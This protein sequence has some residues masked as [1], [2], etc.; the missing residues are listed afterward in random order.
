MSLQPECQLTCDIIC[1]KGIQLLHQW[2]DL[3]SQPLF[4]V[5]VRRVADVRLLHTQPE[6]KQQN[7]N[8]SELFAFF[9]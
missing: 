2:E 9:F 5:G 8:K 1:M 7:I 6:G 3:L 4:I